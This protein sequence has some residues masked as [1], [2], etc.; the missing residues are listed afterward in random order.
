M[1]PKIKETIIVEGRYDKIK[2]CS[3]IDANVITTEGFGIFKD[4]QKREFI[5][6][7]AEVTGVIIMTDPDSA[8]FMIRSF[9]SQG[10]DEKKIKHAY[11]PDFFG[12]EKRKTEA[13][14][15]GKLG[16]EGVERKVILT[17]LENAGATIDGKAGKEAEEKITKLDLYADGFSGGENSALMRKILL[18][19]L[20]LPERTSVNQ[21][22]R[23]INLLCTEEEYKK[24]VSEIKEEMLK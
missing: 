15:E 16:V 13:G 6:K 1:K 8:G 21:L 5:R 11:I 18:K 2:L 4:K 9:I 24:A 22:C 14:K 3:I 7:M 17:A 12:K 23:V 19:K 10:I 20:N